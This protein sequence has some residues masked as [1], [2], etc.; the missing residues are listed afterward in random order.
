MLSTFTL[1]LSGRGVVSCIVTSKG[2]YGTLYSI[3]NNV[4]QKLQPEFITQFYL[5]FWLSHSSYKIGTLVIAIFW[6]TIF[7]SLLINMIWCS[8]GSSFVRLSL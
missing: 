2:L 3:S 4:S 6:Q 7:V 8:M 1:S 5:P